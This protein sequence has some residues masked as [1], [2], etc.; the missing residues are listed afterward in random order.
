MLLYYSCFM[1][2]VGEKILVEEKAKKKKKANANSDVS[3]CNAENQSQLR[4]V[5]KAY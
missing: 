4:S 5:N 2:K 3:I 1:W